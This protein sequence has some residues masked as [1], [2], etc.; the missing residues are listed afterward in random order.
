MSHKSVLFRDADN[1]F[2][3]GK[4]ESLTFPIKVNSF[5]RVNSEKLPIE[6]DDLGLN[7]FYIVDVKYVG[8]NIQV[9][10]EILITVDSDEIASPQL[11][12]IEHDKLLEIVNDALNRSSP[13]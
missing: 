3:I 10:P 1:Q 8:T 2:Y 5:V 7:E 9:T 13:D 12:D 11:F 6:C 4:I